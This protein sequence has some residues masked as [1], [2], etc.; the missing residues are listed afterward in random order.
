MSVTAPF[1]TGDKRGCHGLST[2]KLRYGYEPRTRERRARLFHDDGSSIRRGVLQGRFD[3]GLQRGGSTTPVG[4][5]VEA[6]SNRTVIAHRQQLRF[7]AMR[8]Q[9]GA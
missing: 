7:S 1:G 9:A 4:F 3:G 6:N 5:Q 2:G 8:L